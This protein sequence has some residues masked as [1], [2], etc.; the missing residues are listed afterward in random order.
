MQLPKD[1]LDRMKTLLKDE[2]DAFISSYDK[3][4]NSGIR[5]NTLKCSDPERLYSELKITGRV[6]WCPC[7]YY[8]DRSALSGNH[9]YHAAGVFYFQEPSAMCAAEGLPIGD[10]PH[11]L[12]LCAAPGGKTTQIAARMNNRGLLVSNEIISKRAAI[13]SENVERLGLTNTIVTNESPSSL[14][15]KFPSFFDGIIVDAPCS[16][17]GMFRKEPQAAEEWSVQHTLSCA[18]RQ[19]NILD[20]AYKMLKPGGFLMYSTCTFSYDE[21]EAVVKYMTDTHDMEIC[22]IPQLSMLS[23]GIGDDADIKKC[24]R[25]F[26]HMQNGEGHFAALLRKSVDA[27]DSEVNRKKISKNSKQTADPLLENAVQ[28]YREFEK[29]YLSHKYDGEFILF[30]SRLYLMPEKINTDKLRIVRCGLQLG[31]IK[32]NRFE[33]SH[34]LSHAAGSVVCRNSIELSL[35]SPILKQY[36]HGDVIP[37]NAEGWC[38]ITAEGYPIGWGKGSGGTIKN[39]YPKHLRTMS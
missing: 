7:G 4:L 17:E 33:P 26:P 29:K 9:P 19:K 27:P 35:D 11:I 38:I 20:D 2:Y 21:N 28:L 5:I 3:Q 32:K 30:G 12:D 37:G 6:D 13:L 1:F 8:S 36:M 15:D 31:E 24:R 39:H 23:N 18:A 14:A 10:D 22:S 25:I 16:G 34:A